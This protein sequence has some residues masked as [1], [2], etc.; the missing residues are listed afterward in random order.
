MVENQAALL[1]AIAEP[2]IVPSQTEFHIHPERQLYRHIGVQHPGA[3]PSG[4]LRLAVFQ[5]AVMGIVDGGHFVQGHVPFPEDGVP[6]KDFLHGDGARGQLCGRFEIGRVGQAPLHGHQEADQIPALVRGDQVLQQGMAAQLAFMGVV[7]FVKGIVVKASHQSAKLLLQALIHI[8]VRGGVEP[9]G[10]GDVQI[11]GAVLEAVLYP[12]HHCALG[13]VLVLEPFMPARHSKGKAQRL[14]RVPEAGDVR[15]LRVL[16]QAGGEDAHG[17]Q[18]ED[19]GIR[20]GGKLL[21]QAIQAAEGSLGVLYRNGLSG[22]G[23]LAAV[24]WGTAF[25]RM[26]V[27]LCPIA[28]AVPAD[29]FGRI[30]PAA[31]AFQQL[32]LLFHLFIKKGQGGNLLNALC[33]H[34]PEKGIDDFFQLGQGSDLPVDFRYLV[35]EY[36]HQGSN[37]RI[38]VDTEDFPDGNLHF[39]QYHNLLQPLDGGFVVITIGF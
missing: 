38:F 10:K 9:A 18:I 11:S 36:F 12:E 31:L 34:F 15:L 8:E 7:D 1:G 35:R 20:T 13:A 37:L 25:P 24:P 22:A 33:S 39:A 32:H 27:R 29:R 19:G 4:V 6:G 28:L 30:L 5:D 14:Y 3:D 23:G 16:F 2:F 26:A 17:G 21:L